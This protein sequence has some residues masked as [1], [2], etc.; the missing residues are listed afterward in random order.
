MNTTKKQ[1]TEYGFSNYTIT[2]SGKVYKLKPHLRELKRDNYNRFY[3]T[4]DNGNKKRL[5]LK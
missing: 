2:K 5:P 3:L 4:D 1:L